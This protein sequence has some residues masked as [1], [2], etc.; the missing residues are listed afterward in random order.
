MS[1]SLSLL[2]RGIR[3]VLRFHFFMILILVSYVNDVKTYKLKTEAERFGMK[4]NQFKVR[5]ILSLLVLILQFI[6]M[7]LEVSVTSI[8][9][10]LVHSFI[11]GPAEDYLTVRY[12]FDAS[13]IHWCPSSVVG[14]LVWL[15]CPW[16]IPYFHSQFQNISFNV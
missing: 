2:A 9:R 7:F 3:E 15:F 12:F 8:F 11:Q 13:K 10:E 16:F 14:T 1:Q 6:N 5:C 4:L